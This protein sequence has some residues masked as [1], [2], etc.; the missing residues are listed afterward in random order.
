MNS[1]EARGSIALH[2]AVACSD[3]PIECPSTPDGVDTKPMALAAP[4]PLRRHRLSERCDARSAPSL[5]LDLSPDRRLS[6]C[7]L[8]DMG[9]FCQLVGNATKNCSLYTCPSRLCHHF[10]TSKSALLKQHVAREGHLAVLLK[11]ICFFNFEMGALRVA[12][13]RRDPPSMNAYRYSA[14]PLNSGPLIL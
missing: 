9:S 7:F 1:H 5:G 14:G 8:Y 13:E 2:E 6:H 4:G 3:Q 12:F 11:K 10:Q